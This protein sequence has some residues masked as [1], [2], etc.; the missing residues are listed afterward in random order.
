MVT[1]NRT[2]TYCRRI[3]WLSKCLTE[4]YMVHTHIMHAHNA[5]CINYRRH[6]PTA[7]SVHFHLVKFAFFFLLLF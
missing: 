3:R 2:L 7:V 6:R 5:A 4:N 1:V